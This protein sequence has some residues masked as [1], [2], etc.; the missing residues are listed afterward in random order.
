MSAALLS[1]ILAV[2]YR[3]SAG[4]AARQGASSR[5]VMLQPVDDAAALRL[6]ALEH[7]GERAVGGARPER[8]R[9]VAPARRGRSRR[10]ATSCRRAPCRATR[11]ARAMLQR[12]D[13]LA[14]LV[15][16]QDFA[17]RP[18]ARPARRCSCSL[19]GSDP[20]TAAR[21][22]GVHQPGRARASTPRARRRRGTAPARRARRPID[23]RQR[24]WFNPTLADRDFFLA[25]LAGMLLT[26]LCLSASSLGI[27]GE[28]ESGTYEQM[29]VAADD[30]GRDR[31]RQAACPYVVV[32]YGLLAFAIL[33]SGLVFGIWPRG[34]WLG[35]RAGHAA[36][37]ARLAGDRRASSRRSR[38][39]RRRRCSSRSSSSCRRSC[40]RA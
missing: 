38:A 6:R 14:L 27:V 9:R 26:N 1:N 17:P 4:P 20:L 39:P 35:A 23:V 11:R 19:D 36:L 16:P 31:A 30:A 34:S 12:G 8:T 22:L 25:D 37:R 3:E 13:A 2:A 33:G 32:G 40:S 10:P 5:T 7:A 29:L 28:R 21:V 24:F 15:M 18:R